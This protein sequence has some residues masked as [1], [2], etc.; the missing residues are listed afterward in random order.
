[1]TRSLSHCQS[2][3]FALSMKAYRSP[4]WNWANG[5]KVV[6]CEITSHRWANS[7]TGISPSNS[8]HFQL[9]FLNSS[10]S[11]LSRG[12]GWTV[13]NIN[14]GGY[15]EWAEIRQTNDQE[16]SLWE[17]EENPRDHLKEP[18]KLRRSLEATCQDHTQRSRRQRQDQNPD[19]FLCSTTSLHI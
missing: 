2:H 14:H 5:G 1:M 11:V 18:G 6:S 16:P 13:I 12:P 3:L 15:Y 9:L 8:P 10:R 4:S 17:L 7:E 19:P